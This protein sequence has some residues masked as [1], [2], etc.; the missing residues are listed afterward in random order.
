[1]LLFHFGLNLRLRHNNEAKEIDNAR[2][3]TQIAEDEGA[4]E[5]LYAIAHHYLYVL[6]FT[7]MS[8]SE[9]VDYFNMIRDSD[10]LQMEDNQSLTEAGL[11]TVAKSM[12]KPAEAVPGSEVAE[13]V[14]RDLASVA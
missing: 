3:K 7:R 14:L 5:K 6:P 12:P 4:S 13:R 8:E 10:W 9:C 1:M 2:S 11:R